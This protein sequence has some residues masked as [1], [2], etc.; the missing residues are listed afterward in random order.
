MTLPQEPS[1]LRFFS[2]LLVAMLL[3]SFTAN[4]VITL[5]N[6]ESYEWNDESNEGADSKEI[7]ASDALTH[8]QLFLDIEFKKLPIAFHFCNSAEHHPE[9]CVPP[10]E[11]A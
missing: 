7:V 5:T 6:L 10:P 2:T 3:I 9:C 1:I 4:Q 11:K 8:R